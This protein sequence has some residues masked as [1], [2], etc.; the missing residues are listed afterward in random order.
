MFSYLKKHRISFVIGILLTLVMS[1]V[2]PVFSIFLSTIINGL[3]EL[4]SSSKRDSGRSD[5]NIA[6]LM[7]LILAIVIFLFTLIRDYLTY[8]VGDEI[9]TNM[10]K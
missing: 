9:T 6:S 7:F 4:T 1:C 3:F 10:R 8:V 5:A 2:Y